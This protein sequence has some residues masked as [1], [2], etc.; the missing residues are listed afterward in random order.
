MIKLFSVRRE[1]Q[2]DVILNLPLFPTTTIGSFLKLPKCAVESKVQK[3]ELNQQY[4]DLPKKRDS[5]KRFVSRRNR[6]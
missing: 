1:K 3:G 5:R 6:Y 4:D 2:T